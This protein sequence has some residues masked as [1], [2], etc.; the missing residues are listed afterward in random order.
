MKPT[1]DPPPAFDS[2][3]APQGVEPRAD[4]PSTGP[5]TTAAD[6]RA[7]QIAAIHED[8]RQQANVDTR[9]DSTAYRRKEQPAP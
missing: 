4:P 5:T 1:K 6:A 9:F 2:E 8:R 3:D 7:A